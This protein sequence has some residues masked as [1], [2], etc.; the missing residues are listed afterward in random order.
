MIQTEKDLSPFAPFRQGVFRMLWSTG[1]IAN[2]CIW[3]SDVS[4][5]WMMTKLTNNP[6][7]VALVQTAS[8]LPVF[9]LGLPSGALADSLD[10]KKYLLFTQIW[11]AVSAALLSLA[12]F[13]G[14]MTPLLLLTL[15]FVSGIGLAMRMPV[16]AAVVPEMVPRT[17][18]H[19]AMALNSVSMNASRIIGPIAAGALIAFAGTAWVFLLNAVLSVLA[20]LVISRWKNEIKPNPLG[21]ERLG[22]AMRIGRQYVAQSRHLKGVLLRLGIFFFCTTTLTAMLP[23]LAQNMQGGGAGGFS[24]LLGSM[25]A[26]AIA[27]AFFLP[28]L[29]SRYS[30]DALVLRCSALLTATILT[31]A[32][33]DQIW[34]AAPIMVIAG[35]A[36]IVAGNTLSVA[37]QL[38]LPDWVRA[39]GM[40]ISQMTVMGASALGA[41]VWGQIANMTSIPLSLG[42][43]AGLGVFA[44]AL[45]NRLWPETGTLDDLTPFHDIQSPKIEETPTDGRVMVTIEYCVDP[46]HAQEFRALMLNA[47][48]SSRLRHGALSW[49][50]VQDL[51][52]KGRFVEVITDES[53]T[54][55]LR[56]FDRLTA[57]DVELRDRKLAFHLGENEPA[58]ARYLVETTVKKY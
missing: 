12:V 26:G 7:W 56:R 38:G 1:L 55:H 21:P 18:L 10:R 24:L 20:A 50:L 32:W 46:A 29:R 3:M 35:A 42:I 13:L 49:E 6:L 9:L 17:Q 53:W 19:A 5:A 48:R 8:M 36:W 54:D 28:W 47:G 37:A 52:N 27:S 33:A 14:L 39:R 16:L 22:T 25:G 31:M 51:N 11:V 30:R 58:I 2:V 45:V 41:A 44:M 57:A 43:A 15:T 40:S 23:L 34:L 4:A